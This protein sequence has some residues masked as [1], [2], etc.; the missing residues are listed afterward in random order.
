MCVLLRLAQLNGAAATVIGRVGTVRVLVSL[1]ESS[2]AWGKKD[3]AMAL[4]ELCSGVRENRTRVLEVGTVRAF[5]YL[6]VDPESGMVD[7]T[8]YMLHTL[9]GTMEGCTAA[10]D[11]GVMPMLVE[12]VEVGTSGKRRWLGEGGG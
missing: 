9:V 6:M 11:E 5:L 4:Y 3:A 10:V 2:N 8:A 1:Q 7:K 12:M